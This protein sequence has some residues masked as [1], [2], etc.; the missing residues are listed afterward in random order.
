[1]NH[2]YTSDHIDVSHVS[3]QTSTAPSSFK[4]LTFMALKKVWKLLVGDRYLAVSKG[5]W[6]VFQGNS[7][8]NHTFTVYPSKMKAGSCDFSI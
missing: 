4:V 1:M 3:H 6:I 2:S 5:H 7:G 8:G